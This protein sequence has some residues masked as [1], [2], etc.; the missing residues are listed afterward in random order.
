MFEIESTGRKIFNVVN[1]ILMVGLAVMTAY[2]MLYVIF[3]SF[4]EPTQFIGF[5]GI[6]LKPLGFYTEAYELVFRDS[7]IFTGYMNT[8]FIVVVGVTVNILV[9]SLGAYVL[10]R[11]SFV[12]RNA[13]MVFIMV[14]MYVS[15]GLI[16]FYLLVKGLH[17]DGTLWSLILP[18]AISTF[19]L[20]IMRTA[21][22][23][24]PASLE[25]SAKIDGASHWT[26]MFR[27]VLPLSMPT[28]AVMILYYGVGHWNSWFNASIFLQGKPQLYP[29][30]LVLREILIQNTATDMTLATESGDVSL[31]TEIIKYAVIVVATLPILVLY[32]FLQKYFVS[33]LKV[34]GVKE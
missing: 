13:V 30:Q 14:T 25:E 9:T 3:A 7:R 8:L 24:V 2:P 1:I 16:P 23:G 32:P 11:K 31:V 34:G 12:Y 19:N 10:S 5:E 27:I 29:L 20:I 15:G 6:L 21:F 22:E 28:V 18:N 33:G 4:S 26:I 17:L